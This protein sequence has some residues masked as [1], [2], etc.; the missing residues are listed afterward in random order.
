MATPIAM[1]KQGQSVETCV[2][3]EW[4]K[5]KGDDVKE[6]DILFTY[7]TDKASFEFESPVAGTM[8]ETFFEPD[9]DIPVLTNVAVVGN[10]DEDVSEFSPSGGTSSDEPAQSAEPSP[11]PAATATTEEKPSAA[12]AVPETAVEEAVPSNGRAKISPRARMRAQEKGVDIGKVKGTGPGG[13]II[14]SDID[15]FLVTH[16]Q[17]TRA[18]AAVQA[19][20]GA[21][22]PEAGTAFGGRVS[23]ADMVAEPQP[24]AAGTAPSSVQ[25]D[26]VEVKISNMRK[27]IGSRMMDSLQQS[28]QL[29]M[30]SSA[31]ARALMAYRKKI[32][33]K[34]KDLGLA[35]INITDLISFAVSRILPQYPE[36]NCHYENNRLLQYKNVHLAMAVDTPRGL[37]VPVIRFANQLS[38]NDLSLS[39]KG[40]AGQAREGAV[41]PDLLSGGTITITNLGSFGIE[42]FTPILN[43][44]QVAILGVNTI[45]PKPVISGDNGEY[46]MAPHIG[47]SLTIDHRVVDGAPAARFMK[48]LCTAIENIDLTLANA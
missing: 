29:T 44:P 43:R 48:G 46:S 13:R 42:Y 37:L 28:A 31:D 34:G 10:S 8:L 32:K 9:E 2:I 6:G 41:N 35:D 25:D 22:T 33:Q 4:H 5:N 3:L 36:L 24:A 20:T 14:E 21:A 47:F 12:E 39:I 11:V 18:A 26:I 15:A 1:P 38:L 17:P 40:L 45:T 16:P 30:H 23:T 19:A 27:I 7:E